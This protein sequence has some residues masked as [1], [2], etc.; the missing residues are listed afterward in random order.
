MSTVLPSPINIETRDG[1]CRSFRFQPAGTGPWPAV[2]VYMDALAIRPALLELGQ[3]IADLGYAVLVPDLFYR[4]GPYEAMD[5]RTVFADP[6]G[7]KE[8][9]E[10]FMVHVTMDNMM[11]DTAAFLDFLGAQSDVKP[12]PVGTVGY[13]MGGR[14]ALAAAG[15]WPGRIAACASFHGANLATDGDDSPHRLASKIK[16]RVFVAGATGDNSF[17]DEMKQRLETALD[18]AGVA[19][20]VE[21][22]PAKHGWTFHDT[23]VYDEAC[24][25]R[26]LQVLAQLFQATL[27]H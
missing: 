18:N 17:P 24:F 9:R 26:H 22:W 13:C 12:G 27:D 10:K 21:T 20:T 5:P 4:S 8:L 3:R 25:E 15:T 2:I 16:A 23:P 19:H 11:S 6:D 7:F 1:N 14:F